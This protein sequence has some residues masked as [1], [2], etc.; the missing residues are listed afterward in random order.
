MRHDPSLR[1]SPENS[2]KTRKVNVNL[3]VRVCNRPAAAACGSRIGGGFRS[4][5]MLLVLIF[6]G[7][8]YMPRKSMGRGLAKGF[9]LD[10]MGAVEWRVPLSR[11][12][13]PEE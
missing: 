4:P 1:I 11:V 12:I 9:H 2:L 5:A 8:M 13:E 3:R 6:V 10:M 7:A